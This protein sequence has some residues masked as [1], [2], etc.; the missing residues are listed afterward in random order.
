MRV[1]RELAKIRAEAGAALRFMDTVK[2]P[3]D[4]AQKKAFA[5]SYRAVQEA[6][7]KAEAEY[8]RA[9]ATMTTKELIEMVGMVA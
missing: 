8:Q 2:V 3:I 7:L 1:L 6:Y 5:T 9:T 4:P